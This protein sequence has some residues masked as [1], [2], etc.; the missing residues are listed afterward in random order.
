MA[1][2]CLADAATPIFALLAVSATIGVIRPSRNEVGPFFAIEQAANVRSALPGEVAARAWIAAA[3][4]N[5]F[6]GMQAQYGH[7]PPSS[8]R[9][10]MATRAPR[11]LAAYAAAWPGLAGPDDHEIVGVVHRAHSAQHDNFET[12]RLNAWAPILSASAMV[13]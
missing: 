10:T 12:S 4:S 11:S 8:S 3:W 9:S 5:A 1:A 6:D 13:G 2:A 7:E